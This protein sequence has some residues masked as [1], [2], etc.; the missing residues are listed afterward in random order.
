[1]RKILIT[2]LATLLS[3][4]W[5]LAEA[6]SQQNPPQL[7][8]EG[9]QDYQNFLQATYHRAFA[10][11]PGGSWGWVADFPSPQEAQAE[12]VSRCQEHTQQRCVSYAVDDRLVFD[13]QQWPT[14]WDL[15]PQKS[16][17]TTTGVLRGMRFPNLKLWNSQGQAAQLDQWQGKM[18]VLH[19]WG[20]WCPPCR[21]EMPA[22]Q[23]IATQLGE[24]VQF[25]LVPVRE[26][27]AKAKAWLDSQQITLPLYDGGMKGA[28]NTQLTLADGT[29]LEDRDIATLFPSTYVLDQHGI[30]LFSH[31]GP[32]DHWVEYLP[33]FYHL[34][35]MRSQPKK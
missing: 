18:V 10:I 21:R 34:Q 19:F 12:A 13:S 31:T 26:E 7:G 3:N 8:A 20:S 22:L 29:R 28:A 33:F 15:P 4:P 14:L 25:I 24:R 30:V 5:A 27:V 32:I 35:A 6:S 11:A 9:K 23:K 16:Q 17:N 2:I 1:M